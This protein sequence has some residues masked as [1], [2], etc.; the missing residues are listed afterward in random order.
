MLLIKTEIKESIIPGAGMGCFV[1][2]FVS[3]GTKIWEF[4][5][6]L[7]RLI[8]KKEFDS[9]PEL[10]K[11][12]VTTYAYLYKDEFHLCIDN[13]RFFNHSSDNYNT[14]DPEDELAT[15]AKTDL[16]P[17]DEILSNYYN[18]GATPEDKSWMFENF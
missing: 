5:H 6:N 15:Y 9:L 1:T 4:K 7:D 12:F 3:A 2:E 14:L 8:S 11:K 13:A 16:N 17:G 18:F 10:E